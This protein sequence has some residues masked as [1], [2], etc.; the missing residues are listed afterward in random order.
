MFVAAEMGMALVLLIGAGLMVRSLQA[1]WAVNPGF[2]PKGALSFSLSLTPER[3]GARSNCG[4]S[5]ARP[6]GASRAC[7]G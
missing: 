3:I 7:R 1:L 2:D 5:T 4:R 6:F